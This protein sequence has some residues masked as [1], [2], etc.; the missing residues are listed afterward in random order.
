MR[1]TAGYW[2]VAECRWVGTAPTAAAHLVPPAL[3]R[4]VEL[5]TASGRLLPV[6]RSTTGRPVSA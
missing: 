5:R 6:Q 4:S 2:D 1:N 3:L